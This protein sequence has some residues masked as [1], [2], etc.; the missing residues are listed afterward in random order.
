MDRNR[1]VIV[2]EREDFFELR[3]AR[4]TDLNAGVAGVGLPL[5]DAN[6][7]DGLTTAVGQDEI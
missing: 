1:T 3:C 5:T 6:F 4:G 7:L 2:D